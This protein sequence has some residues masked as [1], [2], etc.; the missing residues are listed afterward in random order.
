M[1]TC[2]GKQVGPNDQLEQAVTL[3]ESAQAAGYGL[4]LQQISAGASRVRVRSP[5]HEAD[6][7]PVP[8][9]STHST[10]LQHVV[11]AYQVAVGDA[12]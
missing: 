9:I 2:N 5:D 12:G 3:S 8:A 7:V 4:K 11:A 1:S 6:G 10:Y